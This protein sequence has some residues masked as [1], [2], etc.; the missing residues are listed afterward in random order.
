MVKLLL[1]SMICA[2]LLLG[3]NMKQ[4]S[5]QQCLTG[6]D[7]YQIVVNGTA[8]NNIHVDQLVGT[9]RDLVNESH[10]MPAFGV[11]IDEQTKNAMQMGVWLILMYNDKQEVDGMIF[12][13]L[14]IQVVPEY[15]G[16]NIIRG[17]SGIYDGRCYY[18]DLVNKD[19]SYLYNLIVNK[20]D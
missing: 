12:D 19:M 7:K 17:N 9:I 16:F 15:T 4:T 8:H 2:T 11:S 20:T 14:I 3:D 6:F 13:E 5:I 1:S 10:S 18:I